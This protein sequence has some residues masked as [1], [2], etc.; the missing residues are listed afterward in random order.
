M[1]Y[2]SSSAPRK[3]KSWVFSLLR[4]VSC[5]ISAYQPAGL[6]GYVASKKRHRAQHEEDLTYVSASGMNQRKSP[7]FR[8]AMCSQVKLRE[9]LSPSRIIM[10]TQEDLN[11]KSPCK[12]Y[13]DNKSYLL[14]VL[15]RNL[16]CKGCKKSHT[17]NLT[18]FH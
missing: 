7:K 16:P 13:N 3:I 18:V 11:C 10:G 17:L 4:Q 2:Y 5:S 15:G 12:L 9:W 8:A 14:S 6:P 1:W